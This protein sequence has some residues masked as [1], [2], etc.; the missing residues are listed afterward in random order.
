MILSRPS[1]SLGPVVV[2]L[3]RTVSA[4]TV[5]V[6]SLSSAR[7]Y[8]LQEK[9]SQGPRCLWSTLWCGMWLLS[10][11]FGCCHTPDPPCLCTKVAHGFHLVTPPVLSFL[12]G[13]EIVSFL[14]LPYPQE[15]ESCLGNVEI[16]GVHAGRPAPSGGTHLKHCLLPRVRVTWRL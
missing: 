13:S 8:Q 10:R 3:S 16:P 6:P 9:N 15:T 12:Q 14:P 1:L 4:G 11:S 5:G 2:P 7:W